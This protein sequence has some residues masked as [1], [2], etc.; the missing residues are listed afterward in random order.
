MRAPQSV[1]IFKE[2]LQT[3]PFSFL[4]SRA[5]VCFSNASLCI[6]RFLTAYL[7]EVERWVEHL[8]DDL[9][10]ELLEHA[11]LVD[12]GLVHAQVVDELHPDHALDGVGGQPAEL[13]VAVL[14]NTEIKKYSYRV[15]L[16]DLLCLLHSFRSLYV[17]TF[18]YT[19]RFCI[20][21]SL[22]KFTLALSAGISV[23]RIK[24]LTL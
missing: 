9:L 23:S 4:F 16:W 22:Q 20:L 18:H 6:R 14:G 15:I 2:H 7:E 3:K 5:C 12:S 1:T 21:S 24:C 17:G 11:V 8:L 19:R 10:Q 13:V